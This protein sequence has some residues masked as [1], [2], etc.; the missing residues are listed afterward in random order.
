MIRDIIE[1][2]G[3]FDQQYYL[4]EDDIVKNTSKQR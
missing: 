3:R 4:I 1:Y 2:K